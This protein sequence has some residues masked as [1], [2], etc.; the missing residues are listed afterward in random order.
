MNKLSSLIVI[1]AALALGACTM[2]AGEEFDQVDSA[3]AP[4]E[5]VDAPVEEETGGVSGADTADVPD[6]DPEDAPQDVPAADRQNSDAPEEPPPVVEEGLENTIDYMP[7]VIQLDQETFDCVVDG[8]CPV[9]TEEADEPIGEVIEEEPAVDQ[10]TLN[11]RVNHSRS[12]ITVMNA[13]QEVILQVNASDCGQ[14]LESGFINCQLGLPKG[15]Y[16]VEFGEVLGTV[17][18]GDIALVM[19]QTDATVQGLYHSDGSAAGSPEAMNSVP[20]DDVTS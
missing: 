20:T 17:R 10:A 13:N 9:S 5:E 18:P 12:Q 3:G 16:I 14:P 7:E 6:T 4:A 1:S 2:E 11:I 15:L 8:D 19:S